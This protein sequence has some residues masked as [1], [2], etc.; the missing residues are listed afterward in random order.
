MKKKNSN[1]YVGY[2]Q[3]INFGKYYLPARYQYLI[4]S[5]YFKKNNKIFSL[6]QGEP[7]FTKTAIRL[8]SI[9]KSLKYKDNLVLISVFMLPQENKLR[10]KILKDLKNKEIS[11]HC[12]FEGFVFKP[13]NF[14]EINDF[15]KLKSFTELQ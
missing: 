1:N 3:N 15:F 10:N 5:D 7:I 9:V 14:K 13:K 4:L 8:R 12:I 11:I 6:P 2:I